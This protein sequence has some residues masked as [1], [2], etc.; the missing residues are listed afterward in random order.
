MPTYN[1]LIVVARREALDA[2]GA[3][4]LRR[5]LA[6]TA[7]RPPAAAGRPVE[8]ASM[9]WSPPTRTST[10]ASRKRRSR[11]RCRSSSPAKATKPCGWQEPVEWANYER[12]MRA[13]GLLKRPPSGRRDERVP[14]RRGAG[15][16]SRGS[17]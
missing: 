13:N 1:E 10:E 17:R 4:R 2:G 15:D 14:A 9:R 8:P 16:S 7:R 12:W 11:R 3:S 6:A 5:F